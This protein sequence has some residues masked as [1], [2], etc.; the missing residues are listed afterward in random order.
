MRKKKRIHLEDG[1]AE[2]AHMF[3]SSQRRVGK[4]RVVNC[5]MDRQDCLEWQRQV[6]MTFTHLQTVRAFEYEVDLP[7]PKGVFGETHSDK[8]GAESEGS[9]VAPETQ[10]FDDCQ[11][12]AWC[13]RGW[14]NHRLSSKEKLER[15]NMDIKICTKGRN[16]CVSVRHTEK[17]AS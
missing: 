10:R 1:V 15:I 14:W 6:E 13:Q 2:Y 12:P 4:K 8:S 17:S 11:S 9:H 3:V 7:V 16:T 5:E